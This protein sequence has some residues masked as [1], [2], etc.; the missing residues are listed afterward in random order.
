MNV[1]IPCKS[2]SAGKSRLSACLDA[3]QR[4]FLCEY[5]LTRTLEL[6]IELTGVARVRVV[7]SDPQAIAVAAS[8]SVSTLADAGA[9]LNA[10]LSNARDELSIESPGPLIILP[11]DLP[12]ATFDALLAA[13]EAQSEVA[14]SPDESG[15]G[16]NLLVLSKAAVR[17][18]L[19]FGPDSFPAHSNAA[20]AA[21]LPTHVLNDR[22]LACDIDVPDQY[23]AW[24]KSAAFP[25]HLLAVDRA[26]PMAG[27]IAPI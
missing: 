8:H 7:T 13:T 16:T 2:L 26:E 19:S 14:I 18:P 10:A 25:R 17:F 5:F 20:L 21:G 11:I 23:F 15:R 12:Y 22:R 6:A 3:R 24:T 27:N 4:R 1:L 9:G